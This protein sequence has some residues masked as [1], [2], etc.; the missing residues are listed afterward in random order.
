MQ[1]PSGTI[2]DSAKAGI[3][4]LGRHILDSDGRY[5]DLRASCV[6]IFDTPMT[7]DELRSL[8]TRCTDYEQGRKGMEAFS[9][10]VSF[11]HPSGEG[12]GIGT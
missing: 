6:Q 10:T 3:I 7:N 4:R 8:A 9:S 11:L 5:G 1:I 2:P 12:K